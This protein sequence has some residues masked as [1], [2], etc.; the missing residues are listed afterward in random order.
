VV[1]SPRGEEPAGATGAGREAQGPGGQEHQPA[2][3][4]HGPGIVGGPLP[5]YPKDAQDRGLEGRVTLSVTVASDGSV[6]SVEVA[7]SSGHRLLDEAAVRAVR[8]GW[9]F[10]AGMDRGQPAGGRV[11]LT[12]EFRQAR[13]TR[14]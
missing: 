10:T 14:G 2:G 13:V 4:T 7:E 6:T 3:P 12:F 9:T 8:Q 11:S 1:T 5:G